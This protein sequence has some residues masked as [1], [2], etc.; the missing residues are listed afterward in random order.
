ME[1]EKSYTRHS[2]HYY[3]DGDIILLFQH[4]KFRLHRL[5]LA[6]HSEVLRD[7]ANVPQTSSNVDK[8]SPS[9]QPFL[10]G[11]PAVTL[12]DDADVFAKLLDL[13]V[14]R[15][16]ARK[17]SFNDLFE[18]AKLVEKYNVHTI[19]PTIKAEVVGRCPLKSNVK[20][21]IM[22]VY[23]PP[24]EAVRVINLARNLN[25]PEVLPLAF[26]A[27]FLSMN[28]PSPNDRSMNRQILQ[29]LET[30]DQ[31]RLVEANARMTDR[32][33]QGFRTLVSPVGPCV[34]EDECDG[35][36]HPS[37]QMYEKFFKDPLK[38]SREAAVRGLLESRPC[39][40][41]FK[42]FKRYITGCAN[43]VRN[44]GLEMV[45]QLGAKKFR[46]L[47]FSKP[48]VALSRFI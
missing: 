7:M 30:E 37:A 45:F 31:V 41:C 25:I 8:T 1:A 35:V 11:V 34:E 10:D 43:A 17:Y 16:N 5:L 38:Y 40:D 24:T 18:V 14:N 26:Y 19:R 15:A 20:V 32:I 39:S 6:A 47:R 4:V 46:S 13:V 12:I 29:M 3:E 23:H 28:S 2:T 36:K 48:A 9:Y 42:D 27:L 44:R 33:A 21:G 22:N